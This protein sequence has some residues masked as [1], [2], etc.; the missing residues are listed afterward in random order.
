MWAASAVA[1]LSP[2]TGDSS[3]DLDLAAGT[4]VAGLRSAGSASPEVAASAMAA[5]AMAAGFLTAVAGTAGIIA[6]GPIIGARGATSAVAGGAAVAALFALRHSKKLQ[7]AKSPVSDRSGRA[8]R[9]DDCGMACLL[10]LQTNALDDIAG[11][12]LDDGALG[13]D[14]RE[15]RLQVG[16]FH[17]LRHPAGI[18]LVSLE[19]FTAAHLAAQSAYKP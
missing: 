2:S 8:L 14:L 9:L 7:N 6:T 4:S 1:A 10:G 17:I 3:A 5:S 18:A 11:S 13:E 15:E 16:A 12:A 19:S